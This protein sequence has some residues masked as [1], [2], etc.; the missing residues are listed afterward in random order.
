MPIGR[1]EDSKGRAAWIA[2]S[3]RRANRTGCS[4]QRDQRAGWSRRK[5]RQEAESPILQEKQK[6]RPSGRLFC[7]ADRENRGFEPKQRPERARAKDGARAVEAGLKRV[8]GNGDAKP[9]ICFEKYLATE[10]R[11]G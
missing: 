4:V 7:F 11:Y 6:S 3:G 1:I 2:R 9:G 8:S 10:T 5:W